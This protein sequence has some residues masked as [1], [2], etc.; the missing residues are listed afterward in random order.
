MTPGR[1]NTAAQPPLFV[2]LVEVAETRDE[3]YTDEDGSWGTK[4]KL[5]PGQGWRIT[6]S[7]R[8]RGTRWE[9]RVPLRRRP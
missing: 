5:P 6:D 9:R 2:E 1:I 7:S 3:A 8:E 4:S